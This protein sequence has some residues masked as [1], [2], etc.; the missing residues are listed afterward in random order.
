MFCYFLLQIISACVTFSG[1]NRVS[2][3]FQCPHICHL[4]YL[5]TRKADVKL[6]RV[7]ALLKLQDRMVRSK[8]VALLPCYLYIVD[9]PDT[10]Q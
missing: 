9:G 1:D 2:V 3:C 7:R 4:L 8:C 5:M 10:S 6:F